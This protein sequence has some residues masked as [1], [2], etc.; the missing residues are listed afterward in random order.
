MSLQQVSSILIA[1]RP[2]LQKWIS[3]AE[4]DDPE[5]LGACF[6]ILVLTPFNFS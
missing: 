1:A 4:T 2:K 6:S 5:S 3:D